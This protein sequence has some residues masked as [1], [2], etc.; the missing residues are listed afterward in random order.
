[1]GSITFVTQFTPRAK[2][3]DELPNLIDRLH[4][5]YARFTQQLAAF[6]KSID[7]IDFDSPLTFNPS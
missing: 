7:K 3:L 2:V 5:D 4:L 1:L 6:Q